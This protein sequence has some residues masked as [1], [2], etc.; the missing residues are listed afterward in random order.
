[1]RYRK[2]HPLRGDFDIVRE[3]HWSKKQSREKEVYS[4]AEPDGLC[5]EHKCKNIPD[6][7]IPMT[8]L[9]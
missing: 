1:M 6:W 5:N 2:M 4:G 3:R 9:T 7:D 8:T